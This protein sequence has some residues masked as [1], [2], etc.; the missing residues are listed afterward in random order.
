MSVAHNIPVLMYHH[1]TARGGSLAVGA[2]QFE[3]QMQ[4]LRRH[5]WHALGADDFAA[6]MSGRPLPRKSVLITFDDGYLDNWVYAHPILQRHGM[7]AMLFVITGLIG[8]GPARSVTG[9]GNTL[10][11]CPDHHVAKK[12][13]FGD[14]PDQVMLRWD[15]I[16]AMHAAGTFEFHSHT[17]THNRWD[18]TC[19]D[20]A[21]KSARLRH[22]LE[23]ARDALKTQ[24]GKASTHLCWP[25]GYFDDDY[26]RIARQLGYTHMY[27]T[28]A[29][30]QNL[31][32]GNIAHIYRFAVRN[33]PW[34]WLAQRLWLATHPRFG[35]WYNR[36]KS[37]R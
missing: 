15:E 19:H 13:M 6:F 36:W 16:H 34:A 21:E 27:T 18:K 26:I 20:A 37:G 1:V 28:D 2:D 31:P 23:Q 24:L 35:P 12:I 10:P 22:D 7:K 5:G 14:E 11:N 17:H 30:G 33:R 25:Q 3:S 8:S 29:R 4:G 32:G 9:N